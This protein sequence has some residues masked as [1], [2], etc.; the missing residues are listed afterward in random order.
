MLEQLPTILV[1]DDDES[2]LDYTLQALDALGYNATGAVDIEGAL[3]LVDKLP[4][5][6]LL[7]SDICL[8]AATGP[9]L[10]RRAL[11]ARPDLK[12][13]FM[14]GGFL[15]VTFRRTDPLLRKPFRLAELQTAI[16]SML[17]ARQPLYDPLPD[18]IERRGVRP[19]ET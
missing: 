10:I 9:D 19:P 8:K 13:V 11:R 6:E 5:L 7:L 4:S 2:V 17:Q 3:H 14:T 16:H 1:I 18:A 12:V 15:D